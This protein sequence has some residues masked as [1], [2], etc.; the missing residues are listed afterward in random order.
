[1]ARPLRLRPANGIFHITARGNRRQAIF[2]DDIDRE[3]FLGR[4]TATVDRYGW[5][6][7]AYCLMGNHLHLLIVTPKENLSEGMQWLLGCYAQSFNARHSFD[8]HLF[9]GRFGSRFVTSNWH[10]L[11]LARYVV[12]N[13]TRAGMCENAGAWR[14]SSFRATAGMEPVPA[15]LTIDWLLEQFGRNRSAARAAY[16]SFVA[17]G[18][19]RRRA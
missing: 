14:W 17:E 2:L 12:L 18:A 7:H 15:F 9:Q 4:I 8:G 6:C 10:L 3:R 16:A 5:N 1:M 19:S 11:E 13:P